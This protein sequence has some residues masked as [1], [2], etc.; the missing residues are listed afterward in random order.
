M[1]TYI[2]SAAKFAHLGIILA[3]RERKVADEGCKKCVYLVFFSCVLVIV[4][5]SLKIMGHVKGNLK[6]PFVVLSCFQFKKSSL[7]ASKEETCLSCD[8]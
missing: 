8:K 2:F 6:G 5:A 1:S 7:C 4:L 3:L